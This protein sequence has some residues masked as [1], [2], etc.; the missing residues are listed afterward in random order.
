MKLQNCLPCLITSLILWSCLQ[1]SAQTK[2]ALSHQDYAGWNDLKAPRI[3]DSGDWVCYEKNPQQGDGWLMVYNRNTNTLDSISRACDA[4]FA[5]TGD[6][7]VFRIKPGYEQVRKG[8]LA[9]KKTEDL[10]KDSIGILL[11]KKDSLIRMPLLKSFNLPEKSGNW[12]GILFEKDKEV[13]VSSD[14]AIPTDSLKI[15]KSNLKKPDGTPFL[16]INPVTGLRYDYK[17]VTEFTTSPSNGLFTW[18]S[19]IEDTV[20]HSS[21]SYFLPSD[22]KIKEVFNC[23][24]KISL[25][26]NSE[27]GNRFTFLYSADTSK[28]KIFS[29]YAWDRKSDRLSLLVDTS[30]G[31]PFDRWVVSE[32]FRPEFSENENRLFFG[33]TRP[34]VKEI[35]DT[36]TDEEK[37]SLDIWHWQD[38][39]IQPQQKVNLDREK[40][41]SYQALYDFAKGS[42]VRLADKGMKDIAISY[43]GN[44]TF[45]LGSD[46]DPYEIQTSWKADALRDY[47]IVNTKDG[48]RIRF[49]KAAPG[50]VSISPANKYAVWYSPVDSAWFS[51]DINLKKIR[52]LTRNIPV[53]FYNELND[54][55]AFP[56]SYGFMGWS[57]NDQIFYVYD[58]FDIWMID[59]AGKN[60]AV[61]L[62]SGEGRKKHCIFRY[63]KTDPEEDIIPAQKLSPLSI[64]DDQ[65]KECGIAV[66]KALVP[67]VPTVLVRNS[68]RYVY[69]GKSRNSESYLWT[70]EDFNQFPD[71]LLSNG[72]YSNVRRISNINPSKSNFLWGNVRL[73]NWTGFDGKPLQGLLYTPENMD[74][75]KKYPMLVYFYERNA[76][77]LY[78][79][80][81][82]S[83][84]RSTINR[85]YCVSNG[86]IVFVP[87]IS[88]TIGY[89]GRSAYDAII[90]G[91]SAMIDQF[92]FIDKTR[93]GLNGQS[94]GGYEVAY[95]ITRS[96]LFRCAMAGAPVSNMT[97]AYG[98]IRWESGVSRMFQYEEAQSRIGGTLWEKPL[99]YL[100]NSPIFSAN[101]INTPLLIMHNDADGAVPW[102]Q[103][104]ELFMAM[105]RLQKPCWMLSYNNEQHNLTRRANMLDLSIRMMQ[106]YNYYLKDAQ[107]PQWMKT[108]LPATSKGKL[109]GYELN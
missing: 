31:N 104:I 105:R 2:R 43:K 6:F 56:D 17:W 84:S 40:K 25:L 73:V 109:D 59:P 39:Q 58:R 102:Y 3:S 53:P 103:G 107:E 80:L 79:W 13:K 74:T 36:L 14:S 21:A 82:P 5:V 89:P 76:D 33:L 42:I 24:G 67:S 86:Y 63:I 50:P 81:N 92:G 87:D 46:P 106:F 60:P 99:L 18:I 47:F 69:R 37:Y 77:Y 48:N 61:C 15:R 30:A 19:S 78:S 70:E 20:I 35:P 38:P 90:S 75:T 28:Q 65:T 22:N 16:I 91:T 52:N 27:N 88:Y 100:E 34:P 85:P 10:P 8:K 29:I 1:T 93:L 9:K 12:I 11:L 101:T 44:G 72:I 98:G 83:P 26:V 49:L 97:S 94:W 32:N 45:L 57:E 54:L 4:Q 108:G 64:F 96:N 66:L 55:P 68:R 7:I 41:R 23:K 71:L 95:L 51:Y 62:T